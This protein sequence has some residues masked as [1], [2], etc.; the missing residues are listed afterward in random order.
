[1]IYDDVEKAIVEA[2]K[3]YFKEKYNGQKKEKGSC[4]KRKNKCN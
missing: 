2:F 3:K 4:T 1:M